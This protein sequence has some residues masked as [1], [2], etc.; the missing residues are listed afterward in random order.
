MPGV[1]ALLFH[2]IRAHQLVLR[3]AADGQQR[4]VDRQRRNDR[5]DARSVGRAGVHHRRRF[6]DAPAD[7]RDDL[8]DD[9]QQVPVVAERDTGQFEQAFALDVDLLVAVDQD[10]GDGRVLQ[11][12]LERAEAEDFVQNLV[13]D[14]LLLERAEQRRLVVDQ[15]DHRLADF[16]ADA[17]IV[18]RRQRFEVDLVEQL[19]VKRELQ[20]LVLGLE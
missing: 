13:G 10:V 7:L 16:R 19:A 1:I 2:Q 4:A 6:V 17:L 5:V 12:R 8:V 20:L 9:P 15:R 3:K 11:Q 14:L 18:D